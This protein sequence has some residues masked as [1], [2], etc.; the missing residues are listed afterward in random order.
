MEKGHYVY[1]YI[2]NNSIVYIGRTIDMDRRVKDHK[3]ELHFQKF[4]KNNNIKYSDFNI[5][6][7]TLSNSNEENIVERVLIDKYTPELN[8]TYINSPLNNIQFNLNSEWKKYHPESKH[9]K[10]NKKYKKSLEQQDVYIKSSIGLKKFK[11]Y[12]S[13]YNALYTG[14]KW[15]ESLD[16]DDERI[17][18]DDMP[19]IDGLPCIYYLCFS[20]DSNLYC[21]SIMNEMSR[22][23][24]GKQLLKLICPAYVLKNI[25]PAFKYSLN[26]I[27]EKILEYKGY[28]ENYK[29]Q[30]DYEE[31]FLNDNLKNTF[32]LFDIDF[33]YD[34]YVNTKAI[35]KSYV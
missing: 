22:I 13:E 35:M 20:Y 8:T 4:C 21:W 23:E 2:Y 30:K 29:W 24:D 9:K 33:T 17:I 19:I 6:Y 3:S 5:E 34:D 7:I 1:K 10:E 18:V 16:K 32:K 11:T 12:I 15:I 31:L 27:A 28:A 25:L 26:Q 14:I